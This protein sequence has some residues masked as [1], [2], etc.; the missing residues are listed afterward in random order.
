MDIISKTSV[1]NL[2]ESC[3]GSS[4]SIYMPTFESGR[5]K[6]Q[7]RIRFKNLVKKVTN[8]LSDSGLHEGQI[9]SFLNPINN[10]LEDEFYWQKP[11]QGLA[12]FM[13]ANELHLLELPNAV[14]EMVIVSD[15]F[16]ILPLIPIYQG[17]G[18]YF[19]L[20]I[21]Q[22]R[23]KIY[24]GSKFELNLID[25]LDLPK[26][27]Q[28]MFDNYFEFHKHLSFHTSTSSPN[29]DLP[30]QRS[31]MFFNQSGGDDIEEKAEI[32]NFF[33]RFD[34]AL[35]DYLGGQDAPL[36]LAGVGFLHPLYKQAN[37]YPHLLDE[38]ITKN[39]DQM[40]ID[41]LHGLSWQIVKKYYEKDIQHAL[42]MYQKLAD[43]NDV[44]TQDIKMIVPSAYFKR[45]HTLFVAE[46]VHVWGNFDFST[47]Q[48][49]LAKY[50]QFH[51][52]DLLNF[53]ATHTLI[54]GGQVLVIPQENMPGKTTTAAILHY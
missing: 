33:H 54:N 13:D 27:L 26:S 9:K 38:G 46:N 50:P 30:T 39:I 2:I 11:S 20:V 51:N 3:E 43:D 5:N 34:R 1:L 35:M 22:D 49:K 37:T 8:Q 17:N 21:D 7:N 18:Q 4:V 28:Q 41:E 23:P 15:R 29:P 44:T 31:G 10:L 19:L 25:D 47:H 6:E 16:H 36:V 40:P 24:Q 32:V 48:V 45:V 42:G 12:L 53:A 14:E 52:E